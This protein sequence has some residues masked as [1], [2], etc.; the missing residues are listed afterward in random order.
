[1][2]SEENVIVNNVGETAAGLNRKKMCG[3]YNKVHIEVGHVI[4]AM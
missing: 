4:F 2:R 3:L 1:M